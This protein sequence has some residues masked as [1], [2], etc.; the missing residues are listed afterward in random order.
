MRAKPP[1]ILTWAWLVNGLAVALL[2]FPLLPGAFRAAMM[3]EDFGLLA[4][5]V[6]GALVVIVV[7]LASAASRWVEGFLVRAGFLAPLEL[8]GAPVW[9][10][11][12]VLQR[13]ERA[14]EVQRDR[15]SDGPED[16]RAVFSLMSTVVGERSTAHQVEEHKAL[17]LLHRLLVMI[18]APAAVIYP[19]AQP[20][21][22]TDRL[23]F[24][25]SQRLAI[26][27]VCGLVAAASLYRLRAART[28]L[29]DE[30]INRFVAMTG[31]DD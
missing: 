23:D 10:V 24:D 9:L 7:F 30:V 22:L 2:L 17:V 29:R 20:Y 13:L 18:L 1:A 19:F 3:D 28:M 4:L 26:A 25:L 8:D 6:F 15:L 27:L 5:I 21:P 11:E 14:T 12:V 16:S 31:K